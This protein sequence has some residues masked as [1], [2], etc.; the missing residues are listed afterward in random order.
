MS[1]YNFK[2]NDPSSFTTSSPDSKSSNRFVHKTFDDYKPKPPT[3][4]TP[5]ATAASDSP[6]LPRAILT[7][8]G[9]GKF[10]VQNY[11]KQQQQPSETQPIQ[12]RF[13]LQKP[14]PTPTPT[15]EDDIEHLDYSLPDE[16]FAVS[17][18]SSLQAITHTYSPLVLG[19]LSSYSTQ[20][21]IRVVKLAGQSSWHA[22]AQTDEVFILLRGTITVLYRSGG[23]EEKSVKV[24]GGELLVVPM[25]MEHCVIAE[26][27]TEVLL[28]EGCHED[29]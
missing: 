24:I 13:R 8:D 20:T 15:Q 1:F 28:L 3:T 10:A 19:T 21:S 29:V 17:I 4:N 25:G 27:G 12:S 9:R 14:T 11:A 18:T 26:E 22:H 6:A 16:I 23:G 5:T 7:N 2:L